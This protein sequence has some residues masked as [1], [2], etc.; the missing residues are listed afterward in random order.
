MLVC[1]EVSHH[2]ITNKWC[3]RGLRHLFSYQ[4]LV[5]SI[6]VKLNGKISSYDLS[7]FKCCSLAKFS[8]ITLSKMEVLCLLRKFKSVSKLIFNFVPYCG[9]L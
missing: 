9:C 5:S 4:L 7:L 3:A 8:M 1:V 2:Y 6:T